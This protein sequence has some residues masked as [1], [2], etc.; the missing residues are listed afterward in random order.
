MRTIL[1]SLILV[2]AVG[3]ADAA[4]APVLTVVPATSPAGPGAAEPN[5]FTAHDGRV[6]LS[7]L[8]PVEGRTY[9]LRFS[10]RGNDGA[11]SAPREV[12][13]RDDLFVNWA[14]FPS[15]VMLRD[16]RLLA[17]WLQRNGS[18][19][20]AYEVRL[21]ESRDDGATW[22][23]SLTPHRAGIQAEHGFVSILP[24]ADGAQIYFLDGGAGKLAGA[25]AEGGDHGHAIPMSFSTNVWTG[26]TQESTKTILDTRVCDC[27]ATAS[28][29]TSRGPIAIFRD[30]SET[31]PEIRDISVTRLVD[32]A[33]TTPVPVHNDG[34][35]VNYCPV[36]GPAIVASGDTVAVAWFT[37]ARDT[38]RVNVAFSTDAGATFSA[39]VRV[40]DG[41]PAG[42]VGLQWMDGAA[43]VSWLERGASDTAYVKLRRVDRD[44]AIGAALV[45]SES[46]G[47]RSSGFPRLT[48]AGDGFVMA[49]TMPGTPSEV[50]VSTIAPQQ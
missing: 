14:D 44:G 22:S 46:K 17:H 36:N 28:A 40:D 19:T 1:R 4:G 45:V 33:W 10:I 16:G 23:E 21:S 31:T 13:R 47:A 37:A 18:A 5:L 3:C 42:R 34:W 20:Y 35:E 39:P 49:W 8:E 11:W 27:C 24:T 15:V 12:M 38:A 32:G 2:A 43:Y 50:R 48:R 25:A 6:V 26:S 41:T 30:R 29:M 9:A 7:W